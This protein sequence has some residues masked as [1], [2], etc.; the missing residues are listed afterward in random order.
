[1][2]SSPYAPYGSVAEWSKALDLGSSHFDGVGSNPTTATIFLRN[3]F[4]FSIRSNSDDANLM[5]PPM[6]QTMTFTTRNIY[7]LPQSCSTSSRLPVTVQELPLVIKL[8]EQDSY[9]TLYHDKNDTIGGYNF[10]F[11]S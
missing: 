2:I 6:G 9:T 1:M 11:I 4:N 10:T 3:R 8:G 7:C 5:S